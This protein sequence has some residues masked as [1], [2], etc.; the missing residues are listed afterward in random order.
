MPIQNNFKKFTLSVR[1]KISSNVGSD[2]ES[3]KRQN[4]I[5][6]PK[7]TDIES[8]ESFFNN[9]VGTLDNKK[10]QISSGEKT[11][12]ENS[13][14]TGLPSQ[15]VFGKK[16]SIDSL[17]DSASDFNQFLSPVI[18]TEN[19]NKFPLRENTKE[20]VD[21]LIDTSSSL[22]KN[23]GISFNSPEII[24]IWD[25]KPLHNSSGDETG[26]KDALKFKLFSRNIQYENIN[27]FLSILKKKNPDNTYDFLQKKYIKNFENLEFTIETFKSIFKKLH[28]INLFFNLKRQKSNWEQDA[29]H[30]FQEL[31]NKNEQLNHISLGSVREFLITT[32]I[33]L[34]IIIFIKQTHKLW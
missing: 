29:S 19:E 34:V 23:S 32:L 14:N 21:L 3:N 2:K 4:I 20:T 27:D 16:V 1:P 24:S 9:T 11:F 5:K 22:V 28:E 8:T 31:I 18:I 12:I 15:S 17:E 26:S 7:I 10:I 30:V 6:L 13:S 33:H 25:W